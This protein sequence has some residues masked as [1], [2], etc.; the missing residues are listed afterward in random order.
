[1]GGGENAKDD[2]SSL[3][4]HQDDNDASSNANNKRLQRE[5]KMDRRIRMD[6]RK[7]RWG[8]EGDARKESDNEGEEKMKINIPL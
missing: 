4:K 3:I 2:I 5:R 6:R 1:M 7:E 8:G